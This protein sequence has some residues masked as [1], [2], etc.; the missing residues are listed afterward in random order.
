MRIKW[1]LYQRAMEENYPICW[2]MLRIRLEKKQKNS[3]KKQSNTISQ[4]I[5]GYKRKKLRRIYE[6]RWSIY[7]NAKRTCLS[8]IPL[9][10]Y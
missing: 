2:I 3:S 1:N 6:K 8:R 10:S 7:K 9:T 4:R 5:S